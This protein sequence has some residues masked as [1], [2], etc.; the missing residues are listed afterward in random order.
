[1]NTRAAQRRARFVPGVVA[2]A[3]TA[4]LVASVASPSAGASSRQPAPDRRGGPPV[5]TLDWSDCGDGFQCATAIVPLDY[6]HPR[7]QTIELA[8]IRRPAVDQ[9][10]RIGTLFLNP[11]GPGG[12]GV[13]MVRG[14]PEPAFQAVARFDVVGFDPRGVGASR[15]AI[16]CGTE[17]NPAAFIFERPHTIDPAAFEA[18]MRAIGDACLAN[19]A[20]LL[21]HMSTGNVARDLDLLRA[22][23]GDE[24]LNYLG[25]SYGTVIGATYATMFPG[26]SRAM[27]LDSPVDVQ[28][29][30]GDPVH[31]WREQASG[32]E[33]ALDRFFMHCATAGPGCGF[34]GSDPEAAFDGLVARLNRAPL[35]SPEPATVPPLNGD[36][37]L[38]AATSTLYDRFF[39]PLFA[40]SL[41]AAEAGDPGP[42]YDYLALNDG[43]VGNDAQ[44]AVLGVDQRFDR[45]VDQYFVNG[46]QNYGLFDHFW[47]DGGYSDLLQAVW[48]VED[49]GA[50]RGEVENPA[51]A[52]PILIIAVTYDPATP[53]VAAERLT[54][55]LG[56]A[57]LLTYQA[58]G[59]GALTS[60]DPCL[61]G[62]FVT[63]LN[64]L[65]LPAEGTTCIDPGP[66]FP[67][68]GSRSTSSAETE[69]WLVPDFRLPT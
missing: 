60:L 67:S 7:A 36:L 41:I 26:R 49:R 64:T 37:V 18:E 20:E 46:E 65:T 55:D 27:I 57:R 30:Y 14:A 22:A 54:A 19:N 43:G 40:H 51:G 24:Q 32:F 39:Y 25:F 62:P 21:P 50:L 6:Q 23:V 35:S 61:W 58:D 2:L 34:G 9:A 28:G 69:P 4:L 59:H 53:Y 5:P 13:N 11:G 12:S 44:I 15:P 38:T 1:M 63:Y 56:N 48:P 52:N 45:R 47:W 17:A 33:N 29:Y 16:D 31:N 66:P 68:A 3:A 8:L 42:M 10:N